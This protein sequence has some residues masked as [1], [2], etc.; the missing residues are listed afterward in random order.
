MNQI[1]PSTRPQKR[2]ASYILRNVIAAAV[3]GVCTK[4]G[5]GSVV[6]AAT[7]GAQYR[8]QFMWW[9]VVIALFNAF[10][11]TAGYKFALSTKKDFMTA[12]RERFGNAASIICGVLM[13]IGFVIFS[14]SNFTGVGLAINIL[15]PF[16]PRKVASIIALIA[17][18]ALTWFV[19]NYYRKIA[20][21]SSYLILIITLIFIITVAALGGPNW[22]ELGK[23]FIPTL[24]PNAAGISPIALM[25]SIFGTSAGATS[26]IFT[27][28]QVCETTELTEDDL[29]NGVIM[30]DVIVRN[31]ALVLLTACMICAGAIVLNPQGLRVSSGADL[32]AIFEPV[33]GSVMGRYLF[34]IG[35][36]G[37]SIMPYCM[38]PRMAA[39]IFAKSAGLE[40]DMDKP[41]SKIF[42]TVVMLIAAAVG[43]VSSAPPAQLMVISQLGST[44]A[45]PVIGLLIIYFVSSS[46]WMGKYKVKPWYT[47]CMFLLYLIIVYST[48]RTLVS[49]F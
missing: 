41:F 24:A 27:S 47:I 36:L 33:L 22:L 5:P 49:F 16:I 17:V 3:I 42:V 30:W 48:Y 18:M 4:V 44:I 37:C 32:V 6:S 14:I 46:K 15:F 25:M 39:T 8:Y 31:V 21:I 10:F 19:K 40:A 38:A 26:A 23:G 7:A 20:K 34:G 28:W 1:D 11:V 43:M 12:I 29:H 2:S 13:I 45:N 35:F 9:L